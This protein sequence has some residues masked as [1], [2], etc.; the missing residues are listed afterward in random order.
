MDKMREGCKLWTTP[1]VYQRVYLDT[2]GGHL[3]MSVPYS[4]F[5]SLKNKEVI[6]VVSNQTYGANYQLTEQYKTEPAGKQA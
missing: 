4:T 6:S 2:P 1:G 5:I 3:L